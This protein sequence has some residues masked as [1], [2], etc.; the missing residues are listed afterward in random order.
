M[1]RFYQI[2][3][4]F[5]LKLINNCIYANIIEQVIHLNCIQSYIINIVNLISFFKTVFISLK[6]QGT[7]IESETFVF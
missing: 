2:E 3:F 4:S 5:D 6:G 1:N 7:K